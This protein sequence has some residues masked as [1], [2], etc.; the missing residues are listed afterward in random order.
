M[1]KSLD[2]QKDELYLLRN[3]SFA[4]MALAKKNYETMCGIYNQ[5]I[6][7]IGEIEVLEKQARAQTN[8]TLR[9]K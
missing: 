9:S 4:Q 3:S 7:Q 6:K 5:A 1:V 8:K 2:E